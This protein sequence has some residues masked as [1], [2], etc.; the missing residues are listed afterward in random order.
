MYVYLSVSKTEILK[1][2]KKIESENLR[3]LYWEGKRTKL[4]G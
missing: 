4:N 1:K 2:T 3:E